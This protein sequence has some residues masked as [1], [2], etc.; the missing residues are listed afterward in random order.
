MSNLNAREVDVPTHSCQFDA[1]CG[2]IRYMSDPLAEILEAEE[3]LPVRWFKKNEIKVNSDE[4]QGIILN[5]K[6]Y[7]SGEFRDHINWLFKIMKLKQQIQ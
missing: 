2:K 6:I 3:E 1:N 7:S 4:F 5:R